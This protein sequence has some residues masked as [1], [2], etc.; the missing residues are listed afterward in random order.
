VQ[1]NEPP[2]WTFF[3][4]FSSE[5]SKGVEKLEE[6]LPWRPY[7][8]L[9]WSG[10]IAEKIVKMGAMSASSPSHNQARFQREAFLRT[11]DGM[12][13]VH[14][15]VSVVSFDFVGRSRLGELPI[16]L[17]G[18]VDF[19]LIISPSTMNLPY[20]WW[21]MVFGFFCAGSVQALSTSNTNRLNLFTRR[22]STIAFKVGETFGQ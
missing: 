11:L 21:W 5:G 17:Y 16:D 22:V 7:A 19:S 3:F 12:V 4:P 10:S 8:T 14:Q 18:F 13:V 15:R 2:R 20:P 1:R 6:V 9:D